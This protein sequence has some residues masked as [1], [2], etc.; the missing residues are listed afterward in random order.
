MIFNK[1][2]IEEIYNKCYYIFIKETVGNPYK[3]AVRNSFS[4]A[5]KIIFL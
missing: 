2:L 1:I 4:L 3:H 5:V